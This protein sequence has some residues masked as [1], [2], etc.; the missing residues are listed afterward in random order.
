MIRFI[1]SVGYLSNYH[2][3]PKRPFCFPVLG[4]ICSYKSCV[5]EIHTFFWM[6]FPPL[7]PELDRYCLSLIFTI[8]G[9]FSMSDQQKVENL[10]PLKSGH[11][12]NCGRPISENAR[13]LGAKKLGHDKNSSL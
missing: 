4:E 13:K 8:E 11:P 9:V 2:L 5:F 10:L 1:A 6:V 12:R 3:I 7:I